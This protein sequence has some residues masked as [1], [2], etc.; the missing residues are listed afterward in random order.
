MLSLVE[1]AR[2][3]E[4]KA[5]LRD[6]P[7]GPERDYLRKWALTNDCQWHCARR[8]RCRI[9]QSSV[10]SAA[11]V[12]HDDSQLKKRRIDVHSVLLFCSALL[13]FTYSVCAGTLL[14]YLI[15]HELVTSKAAEGLLATAR[16]RMEMG[17]DELRAEEFRAELKQGGLYVSAESDPLGRAI[18]V[19]RKSPAERSGAH[20]WSP[21]LQRH[22]TR[23]LVYTLERAVRDMEDRVDAGLADPELLDHKW[24]FLVDVAGFSTGSAAPISATKD[25]MQMMRDH[26]PERS[27]SSEQ[28]A[29]ETTTTTT[30]SECGSPAPSVLTSC[31]LFLASASAF[32]SRSLSLHYLLLVEP[33]WWVKTVG[34]FVRPF[35][36]RALARSCALAPPSAPPRPLLSS[37]PG[38]PCARLARNNIELRGALMSFSFSFLLV[39]LCCVVSARVDSSEDRLGGRSH[40]VAFAADVHGVRGEPGP[41]ARG[42]GSDRRAH[43]VRLRGLH[44]LRPARATQACT[45]AIHQVATSTTGRSGG[46][47]QSTRSRS[48][49]KT[50]QTVVCH[51]GHKQT[52][53]ASRRRSRK[54]EKYLGALGACESVLFERSYRTDNFLR[55]NS[56]FVKMFEH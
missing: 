8:H 30:T 11:C 5:W 18:I 42:V 41:S 13:L 29:M 40:V 51:S 16:W 56:F 53:R 35:I 45:H 6:L 28:G 34:A 4:L 9:R 27:A 24:T 19:H 3:R 47:G 25:M 46:R 32:S 1:K 36:V 33:T 26:Y 2:L 21:E 10:A 37:S 43:P 20:A 23:C 31:L 7:S 52:Q 44:G 12:S 17:V 22:D 49:N 14:R 48:R 38:P 54:K 15:A 39:V 55:F 50:R